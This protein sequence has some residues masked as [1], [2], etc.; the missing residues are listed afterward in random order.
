MISRS[1]WAQSARNDRRPQCRYK[2]GTADPPP[3]ARI[4]KPWLAATDTCPLRQRNGERA[5]APHCTHPSL[6]RSVVGICRGLTDESAGTSMAAGNR[7]I[8]N[9]QVVGSS[10]TGIGPEP[11]HQGPG[12]SVQA[13]R[14]RLFWAS[15]AGYRHRLLR[16]RSPTVDSA[17]SFSRFRCRSIPTGLRPES[18]RRGACRRWAFDTPSGR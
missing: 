10:P 4:P 15:T 3:S 2:T 14:P 18:A 7:L 12:Q 17:M 9:R 11:D 5:K 13:P 6:E 16:C 8:R 1:R